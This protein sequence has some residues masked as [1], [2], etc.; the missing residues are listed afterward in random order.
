[1]LYGRQS[2]V[3]EARYCKGHVSLENDACEAAVAVWNSI[4]GGEGICLD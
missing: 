4:D 3:S 2:E 1:M